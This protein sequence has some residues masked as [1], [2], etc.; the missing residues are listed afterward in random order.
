MSNDFLTQE[1]IQRLQVMGVTV[2]QE[3]GKREAAQASEPVASPVQTAAVDTRRPVRQRASQAQPVPEVHAVPNAPRP[4]ASGMDWQQLR[5]A[6]SSCKA[7][8]LC[9]TRSK[10]VFGVGDEKAEVMII[11]EAPGAEEESRGEPFVGHAGQ[12]L[13]AMIL[14][15]GLKRSQV[16]ITNVVKCRSPGTRDPSSSEALQCSSYLQRQIALVKPDV[17]IAVGRVAAQNLLQSNA[18]LGKMRGKVHSFGDDK[19]PCV[20]TYHPTFLLRSPEQKRKAWEDLLMS[21][22]LLK[23]TP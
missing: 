11:G 13:D 17:L 10:T 7:C 4:D 8:G 23:K 5:A 20:V 22:Q 1:R 3:R 14:S 21:Q 19:V 16:F 9:E 2:W 12:L 15:I 6:V 18:S